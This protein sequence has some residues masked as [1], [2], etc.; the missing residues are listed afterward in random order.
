M[1]AETLDEDQAASHRSGEVS[2]RRFWKY[3]RNFVVATDQQ[4]SAILVVSKLIKV[5]RKSY[6][7]VFCIKPFSGIGE[8]QVSSYRIDCVHF[9]E[10]TDRVGHC[11][12]LQEPIT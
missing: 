8:A 4:K 2:T 3:I 5:S 7:E 10:G 11:L 1:V 9:L 6:R 12:Q